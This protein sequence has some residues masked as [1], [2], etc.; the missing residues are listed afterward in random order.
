MNYNQFYR[1]KDKYKRKMSQSEK[2]NA[3]RLG[4]SFVKSILIG[5]IAGLVLIIIYKGVA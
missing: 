3:Q 2:A 4:I 1:K 5:M